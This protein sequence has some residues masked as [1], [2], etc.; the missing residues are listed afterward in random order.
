[1]KLDIT[2]VGKTPVIRMPRVEDYGKFKKSQKQEVKAMKDKLKGINHTLKIW[3]DVYQMIV[4]VSEQDT[5]KVAG[6]NVSLLELKETL[7]DVHAKQSIEFM[8]RLSKQRADLTKKIE[9][10]T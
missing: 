3:K 9:C 6:D 1:M 8:K 2:Y 5:D 4:V 7:V 10:L